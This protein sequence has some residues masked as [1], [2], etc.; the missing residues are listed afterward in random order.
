MVQTVS[1]V[2]KEGIFRYSFIIKGKGEMTGKQF[3]SICSS[4]YSREN[5]VNAFYYAVF[6]KY[7]TTIE[8][9]RNGEIHIIYKNGNDLVC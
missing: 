8:R 7:I 3:A 4:V 1:E 2:I 5:K 9:K 6:E